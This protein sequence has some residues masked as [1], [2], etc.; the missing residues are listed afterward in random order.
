[1]MQFKKLFVMVIPAILLLSV[2]VPGTILSETHDIDVTDLEEEQGVASQEHEIQELNSQEGFVSQRGISTDIPTWNIGD[3]WTYEYYIWQNMTGSSDYVYVEQEVTYTVSDI[4][5]YS[6]NGSSHYSYNLTLSGTVTGGEAESGGTVVNFNGGTVDGW[7]LNRVSDL[8]L[9]NNNQTQDIDGTVW[10]FIGQDMFVTQNRYY[11]PPYEEYDF[12]MNLGEEFWANTTSTID[13][14]YSYSGAQSG[15]G[16]LYEVV[17][18]VQEV[19]VRDSKRT[20]NQPGGTFETYFVPNW[21]NATDGSTRGQGYIHNWYNESVGN[22]VRQKARIEN[23]I[24]RDTDWRYRYLSHNRPSDPSHQEI[25]PSTATVGE[26]VTISGQFPNH[27]NEAITIKLP[28]GAKPNSEWHTTTDSNGEYVL[29]ITVPLSTD[30]TETTYDFSSVG[31]VTTVD[32]GTKDDMQVSTLVIQLPTIQLEPGWNFVSS[33]HIPSYNTTGLLPMLEHPKFGI[34]GNY[35]QIMYYNSSNTVWR[36]FKQGRSKWFNDISDWKPSTGFWIYMNTSDTLS[37]KGIPSVTQEIVLQPG[38]NMVGYLCQT[39]E[40][41][42]DIFPTEV[43]KI[44]VFNNTKSYNLEYLE[45]V[46]IVDLIQGEAYW[47]YNSGSTD[48]TVTAG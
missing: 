35:E 9:I 34:S 16:P 11:S 31:F 29:N 20:I 15:G 44:G 17:D 7:Q 41:A 47:V 6:Y 38:W 33:K 3:S 30:D 10:G 22:F 24:D 45:D 18:Y 26:T 19:A 1:M 12:P 4:G 27:P 2:I 32:S 28:E 23:F 36:S 25:T 46:S 21:M 42:S 40:K 39:S 48:I 8:A 5:Y 43:N 37:V 13:G 14:Y